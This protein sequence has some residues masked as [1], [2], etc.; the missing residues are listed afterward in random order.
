MLAVWSLWLD[1]DA[2]ENGAKNISALGLILGQPR[3]SGLA[4]SLSA[5][6]LGLLKSPTERVTKSGKLNIASN[7]LKALRN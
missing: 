5:H 3:G 2:D 7:L 6:V 4:C 1:W